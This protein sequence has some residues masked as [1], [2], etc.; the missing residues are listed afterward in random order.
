M[1]HRE[2]HIAQL[3]R[4]FPKERAAIDKFLVIADRAM[5][6]VKLFLFARL[7]PQWLQTVFWSFVP[8]SILDTVTRTAKEILP[9]LTSNKRLIALLS[10]MWIDTGARP[11]KATF[12]LTA[13]VFRGISMEG[14]GDDSSLNVSLNL[15]VCRRMLSPWRF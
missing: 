12:M 1:K 6:Y 3:Y 14:I 8:K 2:A 15:L 9:E 10:S 11:D 5:T 4:D 13:S 7:L